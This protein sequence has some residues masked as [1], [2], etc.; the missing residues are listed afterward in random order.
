MKWPE[1]ERPDDDHRTHYARSVEIALDQYT[2][3][4]WRKS[5]AAITRKLVANQVTVASVNNKIARPADEETL[6]SWLR[7]NGQY[8]AAAAISR[9]E[10]QQ[11]SPLAS[12]LLA[13]CAGALFCSKPN[14]AT[15]QMV[16]QIIERDHAAY[17][18]VVDVVG[19]RL[20]SRAGLLEE[21]RKVAN[22][23][24]Q[25]TSVQSAKATYARN[26]ETYAALVSQWRA[27]PNLKDIWFGLRGLGYVTPFRTD[28]HIFDLLFEVDPVFAAELIESYDEPFQPALILQ[29]GELSPDRRFADWQQLLSL[30]QPAFEQDGRWN[31]RIMLPLL[32]MLAQ[33]AMHGAYMSRRDDLA[34]DKREDPRRKALVEAVSSALLERPDGTSAALRWGGW[35]FRSMMGA[36][37]QDG[38]AF[39]LDASSRAWPTWSMLD[40]LARSPASV[41]WL[42]HRPPDMPEDE[43]LCVEGMRILAASHHDRQIPGR[44]LLLEML[45]SSPEAFLDGEVA[46]RVRELPAIFTTFCKRPDAL[47]IRVIALALLDANVA[48]TFGMLWRQTLTLR[49]IAEHSEAFR[50]DDAY[51]DQA[52]RNA[53][54]TIRFVIALGIN[55]LDYVQ[56]R[57]QTV[58]FQDRHATAQALFVNLHD[59]TREMMAI[60][61]LG[62]RELSNHLD[63]L[64]V[65]RFAYEATRSPGIAAPLSV[66]DYPTAGQLLAERCEVSPAF[67]GTLQMLRANG[68]TSQAI[69]QALESVGISLDRLIREALRLNAIEVDRH[70]DLTGFVDQST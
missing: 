44:D 66:T 20:K 1:E 40:A 6:A 64:C 23:L 32:L 45:P 69:N 60:D 51:V 9:S 4:P 2:Y 46:K 41:A 68:I 58:A 30:A 49:E 37:H 12:V 18:V 8:E 47:G 48:E 29:W 57:N 42:E 59:A 56:D 10:H 17:R 54:E 39:P 5:A 26:A 65:R 27:E 21:I 55:L 35:L 7:D 62:R 67:F 36:L 3:A 33:G 16:G 24:V 22:A 50:S 43:E 25:G 13:E 38:A 14:V 19:K 61:R 11:S 53:S 63:H 15:W 52:I 70:I 28:W 34:A 31:G